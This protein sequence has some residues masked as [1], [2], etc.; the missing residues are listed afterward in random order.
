MGVVDVGSK[1]ALKAAETSGQSL[2]NLLCT[3]KNATSVSRQY[4]EK[5][6]QLTDPEVLSNPFFVPVRRA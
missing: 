2:R 3:R 1:T 6:M 4:L 5:V